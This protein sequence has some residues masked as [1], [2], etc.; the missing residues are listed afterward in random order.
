MTE[1]D[2]VDAGESEEPVEGTD[3]GCAD[4]FWVKRKLERIQSAHTR[5]SK[6]FEAARDALA[7]S[8]EEAERLTRDALT[9][10]AH[11]YWF[12]EGTADAGAEHEYLHRIGRWTCKT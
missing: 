3:A 12:A 6:L 10:A 9:E 1:Q 5:A 8:R 2:A 4:E 7:S 11:A